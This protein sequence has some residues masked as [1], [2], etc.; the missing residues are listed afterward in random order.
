M[1]IA[2]PRG[3]WKSNLIAKVVAAGAEYGDASVSPVVRQTLQHWA[4]QL[5]KTDFEAHAPAVIA[6]ARTSFI[7]G[8]VVV[9]KGKYAKGAAAGSAGDHEGGGAGA[10][11]P[12]AAAGGSGGASRASKR[13]ASGTGK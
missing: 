7:P 3:R 4:Y 6:G 5:T 12:A 9:A 13:R 1:G 11:A 8:G 2:G 10:E